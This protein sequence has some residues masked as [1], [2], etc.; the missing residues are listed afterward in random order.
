MPNIPIGRHIIGDR[1]VVGGKSTRSEIV[2]ALRA[3]ADFL[4]ITAHSDGVDANL[5][6]LI[7]CPLDWTNRLPAELTCVQRSWCHRRSISLDLAQS[8]VFL[9]KSTAVRARIV[10]L[11]MCHAVVL[12]EGIIGTST[13][14][15]EG[16][17][18]GGDVKC[19]VAMWGVG[20]INPGDLEDIATAL[21]FGGTAGLSMNRLAETSV[22]R[23]GRARFALFGDPDTS[24]PAV[25]PGPAITTRIGSRTVQSRSFLQS[26]LDGCRRNAR[27]ADAA[28]INALA[29]EM[30]T[31]GHGLEHSRLRTRTLEAI[32]AFGT[33]PVKQWVGGSVS[34][35]SSNPRYGE[36]Y[37]CSCVTVKLSSVGLNHCDERTV[38]SCPAC[39]IIQDY[40][41]SVGPLTI[42]M[43]GG[44]NIHVH[45]SCPTTQFEM[46]L[47][48]EI[49]KD[50]TPRALPFDT[51]GTHVSARVPTDPL[52]GTHVLCA[53][54][55]CPAGVSVA[56]REI[57]FPVGNIYALAHSGCSGWRH[58]DTIETVRLVLRPPRKDDGRNVFAYGS[59]RT[60]TRFLQWKPLKDVTEAQSFLERS[61]DQ[62]KRKDEERAWMVVHRA[63]GRVIGAIRATV[64]R[65][66]VEIGIVIDLRFQKRGYG[67]EALRAVV[68]RTRRDR[69]PA[70]IAVCDVENRAS[71]RLLKRAGFRRVHRLRRHVV[72]PNISRKPRDCFQ[73]EAAAT[74]DPPPSPRSR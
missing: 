69:V 18:V 40:S 37:I 7:M 29:E 53:V 63:T 60:V 56:R 4:T 10:V 21:R 70:V 55:V 24:M 54:L 39:G 62:W 48:S 19:I 5:S 30:E 50:R 15:L 1:L 59:Q 57:R 23:E 67:T 11:L 33:M 14:L 22:V 2:D 64:L 71:Q 36:C 68:A 41:N 38:I 47:N 46:S 6:S 13:S 43:A 16:M 44:Q 45:K 34:L 27:D 58:P 65:S 61:I 74:H 31:Y 66:K 35:L 32:E 28:A 25:S 8:D 73:Y 12:Q 9:I 20:F 49:A 52:P 17:L 42:E 51:T 26:L 72:H 3:G